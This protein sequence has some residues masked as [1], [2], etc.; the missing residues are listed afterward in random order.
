M[1]L[2]TILV[3]EVEGE[4]MESR[5]TVEAVAGGLA[6]DRYCTGRGYYSPFDVCEVTLV[7]AEAL[8]EI[9]ETTGIDLTDGRHRRN[10]VVRG[11]DVGDLLECRFR[12]GAATFE[13]TRP[14]PPCRH[15]EE[16]AGEDGVADALGDGRGG[17]CAR[18][19]DP[20]ELRVGDEVRDV[21]S[22]ADFEGL[23]ERIRD[24]AGR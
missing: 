18:V 6:G 7:Q 19:V 17:V 22:T 24:R 1:R 10:L 16:V 2:E 13:G 23:V 14:R 20:G 9:R 21:E 3:A 8:E 4:P 5:E 12:L 15:V 11:G